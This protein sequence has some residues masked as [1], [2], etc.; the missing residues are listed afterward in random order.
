MAADECEDGDF[1]DAILMQ[2]LVAAGQEVLAVEELLSQVPLPDEIDL[3]LPE[4]EQD[5]S[6]F[7]EISTVGEEACGESSLASPAPRFGPIVSQSEISRRHEVSV[8]LNTRKNSNWALNVWNDWVDYRK[9]ADPTDPPPYL[10]TMGVTELDKWL[11]RFVLEV[12]RKDGKFYPPNSLY[13]LCCGSLRRVNPS[14]DFF[15]GPEFAS[16]C[17]T[18]DAE[19]K[20][21]KSDPTVDIRPKRA[22]P[23]SESEEEI[24]WMKALLGSHSPQVLVDTMVFMSGLYFALRS[25]DEHRNL[26]FSSVELVER[27]G[28]IPYLLYTESVSK[29]NPGGLKHRKVEPKQ[30]KHY[31]ACS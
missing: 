13:Q 24:Q 26:S 1:V 3:N 21:S 5:T 28:S 4:A 19:M 9:K 16:F 22:E 10:L 30:V 11:S 27:E 8:P 31:A 6:L 12:R 23:I 25:G 18:L 2:D 17:K 15:K 7:P 20:R 29:N 14:I